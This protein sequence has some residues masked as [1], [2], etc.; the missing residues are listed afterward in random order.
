[1]AQHDL[2]ITIKN[3][4][5]QSRLRVFRKASSELLESYWQIGKLIVEDEQ[6]GKRRANYGK[7]TLKNIQDYITNTF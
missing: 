2:F 6:D 5:I 4:I 3:L 1:M 7:E